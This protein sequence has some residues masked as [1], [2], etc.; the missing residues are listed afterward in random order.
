MELNAF[1]LVRTPTKIEWNMNIGGD[2]ISIYG[3]VL[4]GKGTS[5]CTPPWV[6]ISISDP[7][8]HFGQ[9]LF[10]LHLEFPRQV[11]QTAKTD[12]SLTLFQFRDIAL[13]QFI[14]TLQL[15]LRQAQRHSTLA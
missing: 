1:S 8:H 6:A 11:N 7:F 3:R 14:I 9:Q 4:F 12:L 5:S 13:V 10:R 2:C 15:R